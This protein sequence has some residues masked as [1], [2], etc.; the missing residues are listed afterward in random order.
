M[1]GRSASQDLPQ[2]AA[3]GGQAAAPG[4][5]ETNK[6][7]PSKLLGMTPPGSPGGGPGGVWC[8]RKAAEVNI[9]NYL[10]I[11][12]VKLAPAQ[13]AGTHNQTT[14]I[15]RIRSSAVL[16]PPVSSPSQ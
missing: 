6:A 11:I 1:I 13:A 9:E 15:N 14:L 7:F 5:Y 12:V 16:M 3:V 8:S 2:V 4:L 10:P